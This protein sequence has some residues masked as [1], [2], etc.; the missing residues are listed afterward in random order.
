MPESLKEQR[1]CEKESH[2][3]YMG[4]DC[5]EYK[6]NSQFLLCDNA[7]YHNGVVI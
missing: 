7:L 4:I 1:K 5:R 2:V 6:E 3:I